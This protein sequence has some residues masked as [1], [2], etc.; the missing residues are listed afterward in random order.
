MEKKIYSDK[1]VFDLMKEK[2][3][4]AYQKSWQQFKD[5]NPECKFEEGPPGE[6][7]IL[8]FFKH[9]RGV[10]KVA[11]SSMWTL[12]SYI[13]SVMKRKY[14][15]KLQ[16]LPRVTLYIKGLE[17]DTKKKAPIIPE[18]ALKKFMAAE[19]VNT[20]WEVRQAI[21]L[22]A[23]F[24]SLRFLSLWCLQRGVMLTGCLFTSRK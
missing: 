1:K 9:L 5:L 17:V 19:M 7:V 20:Y 2:T 6:D 12:Y 11:S 23:F 21:V 3:R 16:E 22:M 10:K 13:N 18:V 4:E 8:N 15:V 14:S 24:G